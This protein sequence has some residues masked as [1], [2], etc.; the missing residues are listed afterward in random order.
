MAFVKQR[1][2][3]QNSNVYV[4][5]VVSTENVAINVSYVFIVSYL[6][7]ISCLKNII[8]SGLIYAIST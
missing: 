6:R 3:L 8:L 2:E 1:K 4:Q 7:D 5:G